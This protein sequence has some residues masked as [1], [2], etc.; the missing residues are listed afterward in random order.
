MEDNIWTI[1]KKDNHNF[2]SSFLIIFKSHIPEFEKDINSLQ[3]IINNKPEVSKEFTLN[4]LKNN[5]KNISDFGRINELTNEFLSFFSL[6]SAL[7]YREA[8]RLCIL[9]DFPFHDHNSAFCP[10]CGH[11]PGISY[12]IEKEGKKIMACICCGAKWSFRRL[13][14]SFC[15]T[16]EKEVLSYLNVEGESEISAYTCDRCRRYLKTK[17]LKTEEEILEEDTPI[18]DFMNSGYIDIAAMQNKYIQESLLETR[19]NG[20]YDNNIKKFLEVS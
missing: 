9:N 12:I 15:L 2:L 11:W 5:H 4:I 20:P 16:S 18:I 6:F 17:K 13:Q 3:K 10:V 1:D 14:C 8:V 7:P 19:F